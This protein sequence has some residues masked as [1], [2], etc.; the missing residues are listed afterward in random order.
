MLPGFFEK[1]SKIFQPAKK[2]KDESFYLKSF[3]GMFINFK[4]RCL[5]AF[6]CKNRQI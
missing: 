6:I 1:A 3:K 2:F 4:Q 5:R